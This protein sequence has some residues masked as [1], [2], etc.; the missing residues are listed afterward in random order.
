[1]VTWPWSRGAGPGRTATAVRRAAAVDVCGI[2]DLATRGRL[3]IKLPDSADEILLIQAADRI[4]AVQAR[5]PHLG[6]RL[7][8]AAV[9]A[10]RITCPG[11]SRT[12]DLRSGRCVLGPRHS[13]PL[14]QWQAWVADGRVW[15]LPDSGAPQ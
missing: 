4:Y 15:V 12:Y 7:D 3:V 8:V 13:P 5:C 9:K 2:Q 14:R 11:H 6:Q 1:V 10:P